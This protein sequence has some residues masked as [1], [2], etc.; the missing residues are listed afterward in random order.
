MGYK[1]RKM[2]A[3]AKGPILDTTFDGRKLGARF[4]QG[5]AYKDDLSQVD[6][7]HLKRWEPEYEVVD[8]QSGETIDIGKRLH[9]VSGGAINQDVTKANAES[10][11]E[12]E[13]VEELVEKTEG[14]PVEETEP[15]EETKTTKKAE[16]TSK[17]TKKTSK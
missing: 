6:L 15:V 14:D 16:S 9:E 4:D 10:T 13:S 12:R 3:G 2:N 5:V 11:L 17:A 8:A 7:Y 1:I